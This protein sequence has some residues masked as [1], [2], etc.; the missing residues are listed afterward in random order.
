MKGIQYIGRNIGRKQKNIDVISGELK[1]SVVKSGFRF[2]REIS[3]HIGRDKKFVNFSVLENDGNP[4]EALYLRFTKEY[5]LGASKLRWS[6]GAASSGKHNFF[7]I[8]DVVHE[9]MCGVYSA[10]ERCFELNSTR[11]FRV[12]FG[13]RL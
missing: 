8:Y 1:V 5:Q 10:D 12:D 9:D 3:K 13:R 2:G 4:G 6:E 11:M 7:N